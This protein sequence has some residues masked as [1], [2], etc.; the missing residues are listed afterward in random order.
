MHLKLDWAIGGNLAVEEDGVIDDDGAVEDDGD[1]GADH[2]DVE[3]VP[4]ADLVVFHEERDLAVAA[5]LVVPQAAG[6]FVLVVL[7]IAFKHGRVP[8]LYLRFASKINSTVSSLGDFPID[9]Q[10]E[11]LV[12]LGSGEVLGPLRPVVMNQAVLDL[13]AR[14]SVLPV[15]QVLAIEERHE[16]RRWFLR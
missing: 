5:G 1:L 16:S 4:R 10:L 15:R 14:L 3:G 12:I 13:P 9:P 7:E 8:D 11:V 2:L 6:A